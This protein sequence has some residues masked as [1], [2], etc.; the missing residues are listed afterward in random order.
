[1]IKIRFTRQYGGVGDKSVKIL[2]SDEWVPK[3]YITNMAEN[4][5]IPQEVEAEVPTWLYKKV[6]DLRNVK[7][8]E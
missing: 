4:G 7:L 5:S 8:V 1:M 3:R 6:S 2:H